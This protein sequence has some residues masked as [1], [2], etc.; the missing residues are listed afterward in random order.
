ME[1]AAPVPGSA[2]G[3]SG[4]C[5]GLL[6]SFAGLHELH[7]CFELAFAGLQQHSENRA[8]CRLLFSLATFV[9]V[10]PREG[11]CSSLLH[12]QRNPVRFLN[13][14]KVCRLTLGCALAVWMMSSLSHVSTSRVD[15]FLCR[16]LSR[17]QLSK[18]GKLKKAE[19]AEK[20]KCVEVNAVKV[21]P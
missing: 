10:P 7:N 2:L 1:E 17:S 3:L 16:P 21:L 12:L 20:K 6:Y 13:P 5:A 15:A 14:P 8:G 9:L 4:G 18:A 19:K 11:Y